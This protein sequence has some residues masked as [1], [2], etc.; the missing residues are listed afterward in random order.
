MRK[1]L[2]IALAILISYSGFTQ[3]PGNNQRT[4]GQQM[5]GRFY[6][7]IVDA[8]NKGIEA[9]SVTLVT[10]RMDTVT[11][12]QKEVI[13]GG[14]LSANSGDF[15]IENVP[16]FGRYKIRITGIGY[17]AFEQA[18]AFEMPNRNGGSTSDPSAMM[19]ALDKDLGNIKLQIDDKLLDNV[20]I[21]TSKPLLQLGID[22]KIFNVDKNLVSA[23]G[24]AVDVMK[25]VP[26]VNVDEK[27]SIYVNTITEL[28][29]PHT[30]FM[31]PVDKSYFDAELSGSF[32]G[33]GAQLSYDEG[34]IKI[35]SVLPGGP[36]QKS[37]EI[38]TGDIIVRVAQGK[39][40]PVELAGYDVTDA[41]KIIRGKKGTEVRLT[42]R[43]K[44]GTL[45]TVSLIRDKI[46]QDETYVRS[47]VINEGTSKIGYIFLPEFYAILMILQTLIEALLMLLQK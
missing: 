43:K 40:T 24:T 31:P 36:A 12:K 44:D 38:E 42:L 22:R 19:S 34:N 14:M 26:S 20:T 39:E 3:M 33:I 13:V 37:G 32:D 47:A 21:T 11:K 29:D 17:K 5:T 4:Q 45:K 28:M 7:K 9:V 15:S 46:V 18:V 23:G 27:F 2:P 41:V 10:N 8:A 35:A 6:G 16:L 30:E 1:I 25:N